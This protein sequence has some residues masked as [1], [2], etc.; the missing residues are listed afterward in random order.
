MDPISGIISLG[1]GLLNNYFAGERQEQAQQFNAQMAQNQMNFQERMRATAYQTATADMKAAGLNPMMAA[2]VNTSVPAGASASTSAAPVSDVVGPALQSAMQAAK[3]K[4]ELELME[5]QKD[6]AAKLTRK[7]VSEG[8]KID[9]ETAKTLEEVPGAKA[10]STIL[11]NAIAE[12]TN[13]RITAEKE[14]PYIDSSLKSILAPTGKA[15]QDVYKLIP[16]IKFNMGRN[17]ARSQGWVGGNE[18]DTH[19][20]NSRWNAQFGN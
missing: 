11:G 12:S 8:D 3:V 13:Q 19:N 9:A 18:V 10:K 14:R 4:S 6:N 17:S 20:L 5:Y 7:L 1:G 15:A 16:P 2:G